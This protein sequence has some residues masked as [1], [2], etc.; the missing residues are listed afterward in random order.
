MGRI[1]AIDYG[2]KRCGLAV[3]DSLQIAAHGLT[4]LPNNELLG[5]IVN[6]IKEESLE[7]IVVGYPHHPDGTPSKN[8][9]EI[10]KFVKKLKAVLPPDIAVTPFDE[11]YSS[12]DAKKIILSSGLRQKKRRDKTLVD[13]VS[14]IIILQRYLNHI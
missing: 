6:Y 8:T 7:K 1:M 10:D 14:A 11:S 12:V 3:T 13:K 9:P 4:T 2:S 5:F